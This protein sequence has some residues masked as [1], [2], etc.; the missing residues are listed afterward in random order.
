MYLILDTATSLYV[1]ELRIK[2][3]D[4]DTNISYNPLQVKYG[5]KY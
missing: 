4:N 1:A 3:E 2:S 5:L